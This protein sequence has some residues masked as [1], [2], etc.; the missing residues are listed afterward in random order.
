VLRAARLLLHALAPAPLAAVAA[1]YASS[2]LAAL[3]IGHWPRPWVDDPKE[4][5]PGCGACDALL[6]LVLPLLAWSALGLVLFPALAV[7]L[8]GA[9]P[10]RRAALLALAFVAGWTLLASDLL[11]GLPG[12]RLLWYID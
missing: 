8:R 2:L 1:L 7:A 9:Y 6:G 3:R 5:A 10:R 12:D 4:V 11:F